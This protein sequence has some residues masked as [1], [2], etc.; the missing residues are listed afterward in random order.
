MTTTT[1]S[2]K[3]KTAPAKYKGLEL[4]DQVCET[5]PEHTK[6]VRAGARSFTAIDAQPQLKAATVIWGPFGQDWGVKHESFIVSSGGNLARYSATLFY[7]GGELPLHADCQII[8]LN[9]KRAGQYNDD[10]TKKMATDAL[11]KG[12]SKLGFNADAFEGKYD[13]N[14]YVQEMYQKTHQV[15]DLASNEDKGAF[16]E[17]CTKYDMN[18]KQRAW[19]QEIIA[20]QVTKT[21][22]ENYKKMIATK[23]Q[24]KKENEPVTLQMT[25]DTDQVP[26]FVT[27]EELPKGVL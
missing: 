4:W 24:V 19:A 6:Q 8:Y 18:E 12:L 21:D 16:L 15:P 22:L 3:K 26:D 1:S 11:T 14:K 2:T 13:D 23:C 25:D 20:S 17:Y 9:G 7:P 27:K 5:N 10:W